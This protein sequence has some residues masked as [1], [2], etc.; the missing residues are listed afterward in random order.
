[1]I[2]TA[3][4]LDIKQNGVKVGQKFRLKNGKILSLQSYQGQYK[5]DFYDLNCRWLEDYFY[6]EDIDREVLK[7][8][9]KYILDKGGEILFACLQG[10]AIGC[11]ALMQYEKGHYE[12]TKY[13]VDPE[14]QGLGIGHYLMQAVLNLYLDLGGDQ[15][16]LYTN[17]KL[18][19]AAKLYQDYGWRDINLEAETP[20][21]RCN[22]KMQWD[23]S[24]DNC[25]NSLK[26]NNQAK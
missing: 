9:E 1:M 3:K 18:L 22:C 4:A 19:A 25:Q 15:L 12:F 14:S 23:K 13:A 5:Q 6:V 16:I 21:E 26:Q 17:R 24:L 7:N 10:R 8:P 20:Y 2:L 11:A